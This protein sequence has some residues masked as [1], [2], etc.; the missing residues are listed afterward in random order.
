M[1]ADASDALWPNS[2]EV[3]DLDR[4]NPLSLSVFCSAAHYDEAAQVSLRSN[5][6]HA[7]INHTF[8]SSFVS[9]Y[10]S[11]AVLLS[12]PEL[13]RFRSQPIFYGYHYYVK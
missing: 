5:S 2:A 13:E 11:A 1:N 9:A 4:S 3:V 7:Y 8:D 12:G 10:A 6:A